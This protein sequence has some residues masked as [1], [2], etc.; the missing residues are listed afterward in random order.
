[1]LD[2]LIA[3]DVRPDLVVGTS[4]GAIN[5]AFIASRPSAAGVAELARL[6][7]EV[8]RTGV[9]GGGIVD[10]IRHLA[11]SRTSL[12]SSEPLARLLSDSIAVQHIEELP[13]RFQCVASCIET[14]GA[15]WFDSGP[16]VP[17]VLA[18][19]AV[20][21]LLPPAQ[22][23]DR[24]Y[25]DGGIVDSVPVRRAVSL[26]ASEIFVLQVGRVDVPLEVPRR[27]QDVATVA[28]E[29]AR[30][31]GF[32]AAMAD[33]PEHVEV[34]VLPTGT[35]APRPSDLRQLRYRDFSDISGRIATARRASAA[36]LDG[37]ER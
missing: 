11:A 23:G 27:P 34:H 28:F 37:L 10:R 21:G 5:G 7:S 13:V 32:S 33:L 6:W 30:R 4:I 8:E 19:C 35:D 1:M 2:A 22:V 18:S 12:H 24:H 25:L 26:G 14:A 29:I 20:P 31:H 17:A 3:A 9:F 36:Y 15:H 16:L